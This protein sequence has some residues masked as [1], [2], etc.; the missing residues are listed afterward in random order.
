MAGA[1]G[2][3]SNAELLTLWEAGE[4]RHDADR[5]LLILACTEP[6]RAWT[7]LAALPVGVRDRLLLGVRSRL[8]G[9]DYPIG[10]QCPACGE[11]LEFTAT[12][13]ELAPPDQPPPPD[14]V[15]VTHEG[16]HLTA[17]PVSSRDLAVLRPGQT[18]AQA[19]AA[20]A[21][22]VILST[23]GP[24]ETP[25]E[26]VLV[27]LGEALAVADPMADLEFALACPACRH[28]WVVAFDITAYFWRELTRMAHRLLDEVHELAAAY[29]W[30]QPDILSL[31]PAARAYYLSRIKA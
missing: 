4:G 27:K 22:A 19:R 26:D 1:S 15:E 7:D 5:A 30:S 2:L 20:L 31:S 11:R 25:P 3:L 18:R 17:R 12:T 16:W 10:V 21:A 29:G 9:D 8:L 13:D 28:Q 14:R 23:E 6:G 24:G